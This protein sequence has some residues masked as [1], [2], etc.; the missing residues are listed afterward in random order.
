MDTLIWPMVV[1][2]WQH[3]R[4][5]SWQDFG[6]CW[7]NKLI[8]FKWFKRI[9]AKRN[10]LLVR[11]ASGS[12]ISDLWIS[13]KRSQTFTQSHIFGLNYSILWVACL[14]TM[15]CLFIDLLLKV[16]LLH[17]HMDSDIS[18]AALKYVCCMKQRAQ[19]LPFHTQSHR[20]RRR[21]SVT[22][23]VWRL[24]IRLLCQNLVGKPNSSRLGNRKS[25]GRRRVGS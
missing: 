7:V 4:T 8:M 9:Q 23:K 15:Y 6:L 3:L 19:R 14:T 24:F 11:S 5:R 22:W 2:I 10:L 1:F 13:S 12:H 17:I 18:I 21:G 20:G 25:G 16:F